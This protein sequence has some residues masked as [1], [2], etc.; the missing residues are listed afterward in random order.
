[1]QAGM[2]SGV[3]SDISVL[4]LYND[5]CQGDSGGPVF[6]KG[7][8]PPLHRKHIP[9]RFGSCPCQ[10]RAPCSSDIGSA[11]RPQ[12]ACDFEPY[13]QRVEIGDLDGQ[14]YSEV[15]GLKTNMRIMTPDRE[16]WIQ[17]E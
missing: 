17:S 4:N 11:L 13:L 9:K 7:K 6:L 12:E 5:T 2:A 14:Y 15:I 16:A 3:G 10:H 1:M 8:P